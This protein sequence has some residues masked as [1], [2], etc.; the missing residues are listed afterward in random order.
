ML[1][2]FRRDINQNLK[3]CHNG[4]QTYR[5]YFDLIEQFVD[6]MNHKINRNIPYFMYNALTEYTRELC[7][8]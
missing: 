1:N 7:P 5:K 4:V 6:R 2:F 3:R 8:L